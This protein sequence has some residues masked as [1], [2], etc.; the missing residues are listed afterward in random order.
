MVLKLLCVCEYICVY[1]WEKGIKQI[2]IG[3]VEIILWGNGFKTAA[4]LCAC[5]CVYEREGHK[6]NLNLRSRN[7]Y[8]KSFYDMVLKL[9]CVCAN[10][11]VY[12]REKGIKQN[13]YKISDS[14]FLAQN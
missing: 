11:C 6:T 14:K 10:V 7:Y 2:L 12:M 5:L 4:C 13:N 3:E 9:L 1:M 8:I